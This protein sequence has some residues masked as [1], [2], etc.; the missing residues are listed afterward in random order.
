MTGIWIRPS[1]RYRESASII[2]Q[3]DDKDLPFSL[4]LI[5]R[6]IRNISRSA[7]FITQRS[8]AYYFSLLV[9]C[10]FDG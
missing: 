6:K 3:L 4:V 5:V 9:G 10:R 1:V 8:L 7:I 2:H